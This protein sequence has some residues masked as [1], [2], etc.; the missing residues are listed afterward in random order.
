MDV[1]I[2]SGGKGTRLK[3]VVNDVPKTMAP[4]NNKPFLEYTLEYLNSFNVENVILAVGYKKEIIK[5]YFGNKYKNMNILYSEEEEPLGTGGAIKKALQLVKNKN[6]LVINGD[7]YTKINIEEL[8]EE[9]IKREATMAIAVKEMNDF[10]RY[11]VVEFSENRIN[12][13]NEKKFTKKGFM[14]T[15]FYIMNKD[16]F[17][18]KE[19]SDRFSLEKDYLCQYVNID[20]IIPY[21]Y[22]GEFVDI[23]TPEDYE[24]IKRIIR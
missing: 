13:F 7:V 17:A 12:K 14:N 9:H 2:L 23:G 10:N 24:K 18:N 4:I 3:Q 8:L 16:I 20:K 5:R 19:I 6:S 15:G 21:I 22:D 11:G 1:I